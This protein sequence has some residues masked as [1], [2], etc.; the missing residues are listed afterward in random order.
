MIFKITV[1]SATYHEFYMFIGN[2]SKLSQCIWA[3]WLIWQFLLLPTGDLKFW[4][5]LAL[6]VLCSY[7]PHMYLRCSVPYKQL[8]DSYCDY[9][10]VRFVCLVKSEYLDASLGKNQQENGSDMIIAVCILFIVSNIIL[11]LIEFRANCDPIGT[12]S[13][14]DV[15]SDNCSFTCSL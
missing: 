8:I 13:Y 1:H 11:H 10:S 15:L 6:V 9:L 3:C 12:D 2:Y 7:M 14:V 4:Q 5:L